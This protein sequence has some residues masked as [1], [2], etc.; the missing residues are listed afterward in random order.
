M[1]RR[2]CVRSTSKDTRQRFTAWVGLTI[3]VCNNI[4]HPRTETISQ[5]QANVVVWRK[6]KNSGEFLN[7]VLRVGAGI[8]GTCCADIKT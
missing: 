1:I 7:K 8:T 2:S 6:K 5:F 4:Y 3:C